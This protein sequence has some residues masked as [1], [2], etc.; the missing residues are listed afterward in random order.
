M[1]MNITGIFGIPDII[2][3]GYYDSVDTFSREGIWQLCNRDLRDHTLNHPPSACII[4][5]IRPFVKQVL[6]NAPGAL[7]LCCFLY[8]ARPR[9]Q[10]RVF[11][12]AF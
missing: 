3:T 10:T 7:S 11:L 4:S 6:R 8:T 12:S 2:T 9:L 5:K 1:Y